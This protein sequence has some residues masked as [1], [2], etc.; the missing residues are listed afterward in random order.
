MKRKKITSLSNAFD[1]WLQSNPTIQEGLNARN[2]EKI[3]RRRLGS[4]AKYVANVECKKRVLYVRLYSSTMRANMES[5]KSELM[6][7]INEEIGS[8]F[9]VEIRF[10]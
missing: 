7:S 8:K 6:D 10:Q 5:V 2:A 4:F 1:S 9:L 3:L